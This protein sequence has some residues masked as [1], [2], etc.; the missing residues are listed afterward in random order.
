MFHFTRF[1]ETGFSGFRAL[2]GFRALCMV[3]WVSGCAIGALA[4]GS[5]CILKMS[6]GHGKAGC[7]GR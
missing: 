3:F 1:V 6:P 7:A 2:A 5:T 4:S